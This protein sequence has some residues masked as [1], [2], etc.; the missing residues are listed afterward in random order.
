[1]SFITIDPYYPTSFYNEVK[2]TLKNN[3]VEFT[4]FI[5]I[6]PPY[7]WY[8]QIDQ[9]PIMVNYDEM[10]SKEERWLVNK[11]QPLRANEE[12][13]FLRR[14]NDKG[15]KA[16]LKFIEN[17]PL[18][19]ARLSDYAVFFTVKNREELEKLTKDYPGKVWYFGRYFNNRFR[20]CLATNKMVKNFLDPAQILVEKTDNAP[21]HFESELNW[22]IFR[23]TD[24]L[25]KYTETP[26]FEDG[27]YF[28]VKVKPEDSSKYII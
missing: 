22:R 1:M 4:E 2:E 3:E 6:K 14:E 7:D 27:K 9:K 20:V 19:E 21:G 11:I 8:F 5:N 12:Y 26:Y 25:L 15:P 10:P 24:M 28:K 18:K 23:G 16:L 13:L 17:E